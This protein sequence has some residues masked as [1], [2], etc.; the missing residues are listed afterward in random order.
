MKYPKRS[1]YKHAKSQYR[2]RNWPAYEA[3]LQKRGDLTVWLSDEALDAALTIRMVFHSEGGRQGAWPN[4]GVPLKCDAAHLRSDWRCKKPGPVAAEEGLDGRRSARRDEHPG[5][6]TTVEAENLQ[7]EKRRQQGIRCA[8]TEVEI[9]SGLGGGALSYADPDA[10]D[11][12]AVVPEVE[13][14]YGRRLGRVISRNIVLEPHRGR[15]TPC[16]I[17]GCRFA[18]RAVGRRHGTTAPRR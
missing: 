11:V 4:E 14:R 13:A 15:G 6:P 3:G 10:D 9:A 12:G 1:Q 5:K 7:V 8:G 18:I 17:E 2:V 16:S